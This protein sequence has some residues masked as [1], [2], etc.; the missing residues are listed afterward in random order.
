MR[1]KLLKKLNKELLK[2][3]KKCN[4]I[5]WLQKAED[6]L[7]VFLL[8]FCTFF[9]MMMFGIGEQIK[10]EKDIVYTPAPVIN[11]EVEKMVAGTP[12]EEMVP[13]ISLKD[14]RVASFLVAIAKKESN[15]GKFSPKKD[16]KECYNYWGYRGKENKTASGYSCFKNPRQA[17]NVVG[18]RIAALI[19]QEIDTP[20]KMVVWKCGRNCEAAGGQVAANKWVQDVSYYYQKL[21]N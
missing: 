12:M 7:F 2:F 11:R 9:G 6:C 14:E 17:I 21:Y 16:G 10:S 20:K 1:K 5:N 19:E 3:R 18:G 8:S 15:W 4:K 13:F